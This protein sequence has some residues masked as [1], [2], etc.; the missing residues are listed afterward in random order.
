MEVR[1]TL[2]PSV[3][4]ILEFM[5][6][7]ME[8]DRKA[9]TNKNQGRMGQERRKGRGITIEKGMGEGGKKKRKNVC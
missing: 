6:E 7:K 8:T 1:E 9:R 5:I 3:R 4:E 2:E